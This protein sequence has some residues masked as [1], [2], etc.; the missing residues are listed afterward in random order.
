MLLST[1]VKGKTHQGHAPEGGPLLALVGEPVVG[2]FMWMYDVL[3]V[4]GLR[5]QAYKHC[6]TRA[7]LHLAEDGR[8]FVYVGGGVG[9]DDLADYQ[10]AVP[11]R[12]LDAV[13]SPLWKVPLAA[14]PG[15]VRASR[16]A[17]RRVRAREREVA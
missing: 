6:E 7:Y 4:D 1:K 2:D 11:S 9:D 14:Q 3:C 10:E 8:A 13:L 12:V 15:Q 17:L 16:A 5:I